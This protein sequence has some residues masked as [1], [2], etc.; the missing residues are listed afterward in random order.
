[1]PRYGYSFFV[2]S[3]FRI[4][5]AA[6]RT[7]RPQVLH[8]VIFPSPLQVMAVT[9]GEQRRDGGVRFAAIAGR[10]RVFIVPFTL[11]CGRTRA[12]RP[13]RRKER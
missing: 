8:N 1:M 6:P 5:Y 12:P 13:L 2:L 9:A 7:S 3:Q 11:S 10:R 4:Y